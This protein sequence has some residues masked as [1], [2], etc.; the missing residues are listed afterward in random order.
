MLALR[1]HSRAELL[2]KLSGRYPAD[3]IDGVLDA[4][5]EQGALS[6]ARFAAQY[7]AM[8]MGKGFG[9]VAIR[10]ELAQRGIEAGLLDSTMADIE[11]DWYA[12]LRRAHDRKYGEALPADYREAA[13]RGR[14]LAQRGFPAEMIRQLLMPA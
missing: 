4:L 1:E 3:L 8:R 14:F 7:A 12:Q 5:T 6:N 13:R 11:P 9:P 2:G 10:S